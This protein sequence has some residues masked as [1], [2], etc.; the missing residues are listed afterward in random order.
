MHLICLHKFFQR[1]LSANDSAVPFF[2][3]VYNFFD[4]ILY[5]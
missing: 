5:R 3:T 1:Q 2:S 4:N